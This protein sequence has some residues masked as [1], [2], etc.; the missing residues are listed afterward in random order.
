[1]LVQAY[2]RPTVASSTAEVKWAG[3]L[4]ALWIDPF[5]NLREDTNQDRALD[6]TIED[7]E[8]KP[9]DIGSETGDGR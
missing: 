3:Y 6:V 5:G 7:Q 8:G 2:F 4:Q 1:M 9:L